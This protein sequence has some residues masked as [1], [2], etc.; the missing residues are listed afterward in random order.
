MTWCVQIVTELGPSFALTGCSSVWLERLLWEQ[1][2]ASSNLVSPT[3]LMRHLALFM[4]LG[5]LGCDHRP[6]ARADFAVRKAFPNGEIFAVPDSTRKFIVREC[7]VTWWVELGSDDK[8]TLAYR[9]FLP[10]KYFYSSGK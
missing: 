3:K 4:I 2:V 6:E 8:P 5:L 9:I 10:D 7:G 1:E